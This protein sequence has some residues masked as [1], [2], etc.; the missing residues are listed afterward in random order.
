MVLTATIIPRGCKVPS[1]ISADSPATGHR[2]VY[3]P[4]LPSRGLCD[5]VH[6]QTG[7]S[8]DPDSNNFVVVSGGNQHD[9][10]FGRGHARG[11]GSFD[12]QF[13]GR[14]RVDDK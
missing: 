13:K 9:L 14:E 10:R 11:E 12:R 1:Y 3:L 2:M 4:I 8:A 5:V 6:I 7:L